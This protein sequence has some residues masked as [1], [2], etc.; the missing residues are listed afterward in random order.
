MGSIRCLVSFSKRWRATC[1]FQGHRH[2]PLGQTV[3]GVHVNAKTPW[4]VS[5]LVATRNC[6]GVVIMAASTDRS[7][8]DP[9]R[10]KAKP[11]QRTLEALS[12]RVYELARQA[13]K[14]GLSS[15]LVP[16]LE[17]IRTKLSDLC[18][19]LPS[20]RVYRLRV[21]GPHVLED[22]KV[23]DTMMPV[24]F[25]N[26]VISGKAKPYRE[27]TKREH[28]A[29]QLLPQ[30]VEEVYDATYGEYTPEFA[31]KNISIEAL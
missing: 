6:T 27:R 12:E 7:S 22:L 17:A 9:A 11:M 5:V 4:A 23:I 15:H 3:T 21:S 18:W 13:E 1:L 29:L 16:E 24:D 19:V 2:T 25:A 31:G 26:L 8:L 28:A 10:Q 14:D 20:T 30:Y